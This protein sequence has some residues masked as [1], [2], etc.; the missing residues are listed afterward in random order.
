M[1][2]ATVSIA[3]GGLVF[4][5]LRRLGATSEDTVRPF[6]SILLVLLVTWVPLA[7]LSLLEGTLQGGAVEVPFLRDPAAQARLLLALPLLLIGE[8]KVSRV[9]QQALGLIR[10][11]GLLPERDLPAL[12]ARVDQ[13]LRDRDSLVVELLILVAS[14]ALLWLSRDA[15]VTERMG[16]HTSWLGSEAGLSRAGWWYFMVSMVVAN[17]MGARWIWWFF[18]WTRF[19][20]GFLRPR[21]VVSPGHPDLH[22][23]LAFLTMVQSGFAPVLA[24]LAATVA[25]RLGFELLYDRATL[26]TV[27]IPALVVLLL[28]G[29]VMFVPLLLFTGRM[30]A[31]KRRALWHYDALGQQL[32]AGFERKWLGAERTDEPLLGSADPSTYT[33][34]IAVYASLRQMQPTPLDVRHALGAMVLVA[35]PFVPLLFTEMSLK[36]I[37]MRMVKLVI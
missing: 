8:A 29:I 7:V 19:L 16:T 5:A 35:V 27:R 18:I 9:A 24:A 10:E 1:H 28:A 23:G 26:A 12:D 3:S 34:Y 21:L 4:R 13:L 32:V 22:G 15:Q 36:D 31:L 6:R 2:P 25:G 33:D 17:V 30:A 11:R 20:V 37:V 14:V